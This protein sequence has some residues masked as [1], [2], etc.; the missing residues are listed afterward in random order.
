MWW[1]DYSRSTPGAHSFRVP[2]APGTV[3]VAQVVKARTAG[4]WRFLFENLATHVSVTVRCAGC[5]SAGNTAGWTLEDPG[6]HYRVPMAAPGVVQVICAVAR[7]GRDPR[8]TL[9]DLAWHPVYRRPG[10]RVIAPAGG[11]APRGA[12]AIESQNV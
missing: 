5:E 12:F 11:D 3:L 4:Q 7:T 2:V 1:N 8:E 6:G 9:P 10:H